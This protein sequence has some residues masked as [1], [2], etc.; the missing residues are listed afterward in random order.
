MH[1][2]CLHKIG[3]NKPDQAIGPELQN[4]GERPPKKW[5]RVFRIVEK[6]AKRFFLKNISEF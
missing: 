2:L 6:T 4:A 3:S 1:E 5:F